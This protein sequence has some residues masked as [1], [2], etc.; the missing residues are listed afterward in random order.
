MPIIKSADAPHFDLPGLAVV[1]LAA[2]SRG[3]RETSVWRLALA[4][5]TPGTT[6]QVDREEIFVALAGR[7]VATV[8]AETLELAAGDALVVPAHQPF[9][10]ANP[11]DQPFEAVAVFPVGGRAALPDGAP[12]VPP[13]AS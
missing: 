8:G 2:P 5:R 1:G 11:D 6:H 13:W 9:A 3:A 4:P 7:A 10:L 12:F